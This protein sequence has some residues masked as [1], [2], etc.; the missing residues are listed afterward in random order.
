MNVNAGWQKLDEYYKR[1]DDNVVYVAAVVLHPRMKW[2]C[3]KTKWSDRKDWLSTWK[4]ESDK[5]WR[6]NYEHKAPSSSMTS[7]GTDSDTGAKSVKHAADEWSDGE[8]SGLD[9]LEQYLSAQPDRSYSSADCLIKYW[10][11]RRKI[12]PQLAAMPLDIYAVPAMADEPERLFSQAGDAISPRR[13]RLSDDSVA[14]LMC[15]KS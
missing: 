15:L 14:S 12:W 2:R 4:A 1:L 3:F 5:Y 7:A 13:R 9:Q 8:D 10:L 11:G 6:H